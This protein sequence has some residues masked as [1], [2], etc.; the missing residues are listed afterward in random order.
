[1]TEDIAD[2]SFYSILN[3]L[4]I[5]YGCSYMY[6]SLEEIKN[7]SNRY[8]FQSNPDWFNEYTSNN[9][10]KDCPLMVYGQNLM[11]RNHGNIIIFNWNIISPENIKQRN[12]MDARK[13]LGLFHGFSASVEKETHK[14]MC[15]FAT[16]E[17][18][19]HFFQKIFSNISVFKENFLNL[20]KIA[21]NR[22]I[23]TQGKK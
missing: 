12:V 6:F 20:H 4:Q 5:S 8:V 11:K 13:D 18:N 15:G 21:T 2:F 17:K 14:I 7:H 22:L 1:M 3:Q 23:L 10:S 19:S 9:L 16:K